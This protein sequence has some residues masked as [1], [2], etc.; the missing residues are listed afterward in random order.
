MYFIEIAN[1]DTMNFY[2]RNVKCIKKEIMLQKQ[3][4]NETSFQ[5]NS[6]ITTRPPKLNIINPLIRPPSGHLNGQCD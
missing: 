2:I 1:V 3:K 6:R 4:N 5:S